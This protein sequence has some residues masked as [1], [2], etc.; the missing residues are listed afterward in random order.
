MNEFP[1]NTKGKTWYDIP[2]DDYF[3]WLA[4]YLPNNLPTLTAEQS[5]LAKRLQDEPFISGFQ[6]GTT[7]GWYEVEAASHPL[8]EFP[9]DFV[10]S[11]SFSE[12]RPLDGAYTYEDYLKSYRDILDPDE[13]LMTREEWFLDN[14][15]W[16]LCLEQERQDFLRLWPDF[17]K[18]E[19]LNIVFSMNTYQHEPPD[20]GWRIYLALVLRQIH[21]R[22]NRIKELKDFY[23][24]WHEFTS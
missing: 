1:R 22:A 9:A 2:D 18:L 8:H 24:G 19:G 13:T 5:A 7:A 10:E 17:L 20:A 4:D 14:F 15:G 12:I 11:A 3:S 21:E 6:I 23:R 16:H